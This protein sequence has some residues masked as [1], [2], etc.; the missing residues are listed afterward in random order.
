MGTIRTLLRMG[1]GRPTPF[2]SDMEVDLLASWS[3]KKKL[4]LCVALI[5]LIVLTLTVSGM[6]SVYA[7]RDVVRTLSVRAAELPKAFALTQSVDQLVASFHALQEAHQRA[8]EAAQ[9]DD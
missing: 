8:E 1:S 9:R 3:I 5:A 2:Q 6:I 4:K 7:Y